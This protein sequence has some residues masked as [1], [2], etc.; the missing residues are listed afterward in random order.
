MICVY[1]VLS[2]AS[3]VSPPRMSLSGFKQISTMLY[4]ALG[5][6]ETKNTIKHLKQSEKIYNSYK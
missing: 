5:P 2:A 4:K 6:L 3:K 1:L